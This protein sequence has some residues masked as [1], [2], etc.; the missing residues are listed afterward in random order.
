[1]AVS[2]AL[3]P[4]QFL[5]TAPRK[6]QQTMF[7]V[8]N[9][10]SGAEENVHISIT[11][12]QQQAAYLVKMHLASGQVVDAGRLSINFLQ[13]ETHGISVINQMAEEFGC[14]GVHIWMMTRHFEAPLGENA[15][16]SPR[17]T[18]QRATDDNLSVPRAT[19]SH[20]VR[21]CT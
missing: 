19:G 17:S 13:Q 5:Q 7:K 15:P 12:N 6:R 16:F 21:R 10:H 3:H 8:N 4:Y 1:M 18:N 11:T 20:R 9:K 2:Q 14:I